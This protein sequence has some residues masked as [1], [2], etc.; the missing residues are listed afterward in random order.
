M[1]LPIALGAPCLRQRPTVNG[2]GWQATCLDELRCAWGTVSGVPGV[3]VGHVRRSSKY[4]DDPGREQSPLPP[5]LL[6]E[7]GTVV[8]TG[9][10]LLNGASQDASHHQRLPCALLRVWHVVAG[11]PVALNQYPARL[12]VVTRCP[13]GANGPLIGPDFQPFLVEDGWNLPCNLAL[14][15]S[16]G[17]PQGRTSA[18]VLSSDPEQSQGSSDAVGVQ[19]RHDLPAGVGP[20]DQFKL[21]RPVGLDTLGQ[22]TCFRS[23]NIAPSGG[24]CL[25]AHLLR[26]GAA[27]TLGAPT[28]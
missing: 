5:V 21:H 20:N 3:L 27:L 15:R 23:R 11:S 7:A 28:A 26:R 25:P 16:G 6:R 8:A 19:V 13:V 9:G 18:P 14:S 4:L 2:V 24:Q 22:G 10:P 1:R 17:P 12:D